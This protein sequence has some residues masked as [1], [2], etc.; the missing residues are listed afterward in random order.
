MRTDPNDLGLKE[1]CAILARVIERTEQVRA[2]VDKRC[3]LDG[4]DATFL[5]LGADQELAALN[6]AMAT[7]LLARGKLEE[8]AEA[9]GVATPPPAPSS[10]PTP[11]PKAAW[12]HGAEV[13]PMRVNPRDLPRPPK[14]TFRPRAAAPEISF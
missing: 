14:P 11:S 9:F 7:M 13:E 2:A 1:A 10:A 3:K 8:A 12:P 4:T 6:L 5:L